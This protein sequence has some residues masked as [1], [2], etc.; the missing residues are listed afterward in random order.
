MRERF[1]TEEGGAAPELPASSVNRA[2]FAGGLAPNWQPYQ[3]VGVFSFLAAEQGRKF[4]QIVPLFGG[5]LAASPPDFFK[6]LVFHSSIIPST[7]MACRA[8]V[9]SGD[10]PQSPG[11]RFGGLAALA[12][13]P[14]A[15]PGRAGAEALFEHGA[16]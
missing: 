12:F 3:A 5:D 11:Q 15:P 14:L 8:L 7:R 13:E 16:E 10:D 6:N 2:A 4:L 1:Q 9:H